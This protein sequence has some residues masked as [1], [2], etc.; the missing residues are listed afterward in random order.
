MAE[1]RGCWSQAAGLSA[2]IPHPANSRS[3]GREG[4]PR[5]LIDGSYLDSAP[6]DWVL[7]QDGIRM[8]FHTEHRLVE[9]RSCALVSGGCGPADPGDQGAPGLRCDGGRPARRGPLA[10]DPADRAPPRGE[11][12]TGGMLAPGPGGRHHDG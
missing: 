6:A 12:L 9:A 4:D 11:A 7:D 5:F 2:A 8:T 1:A 3:Q 10:A